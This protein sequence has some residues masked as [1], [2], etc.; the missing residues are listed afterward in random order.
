MVGA[1]YLGL[2]PGVG[3]LVNRTGRFG[4]DAA[5]LSTI[6]DADLIVVLDRGT[7]VEQGSHDE[8]VARGGRYALLVREQQDQRD[9]AVSG[10]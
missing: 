1:A 8:L 6:R 3:L 2:E 9:T 5:R 4:G 7:I 10:V